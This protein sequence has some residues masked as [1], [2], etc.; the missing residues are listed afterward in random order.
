MESTFLL[1]K[2][3]DK[4]YPY[5]KN[6]RNRCEANGIEVDEFLMRY[7]GIECNIIDAHGKVEKVEETFIFFDQTKGEKIIIAT[8]T[9]KPE[10][11]LTLIGFEVGYFHGKENIFSSIWHELVAGEIEDLVDYVPKLNLFYLFDDYEIAKNYLE[12]HH[13]LQKNGMDVENG[14][15]FEV[16]AVYEW[17]KYHRQRKI[18]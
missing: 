6:L 12:Q 10:S 16:I 2:K 4:T 3:F 11:F 5:L 13:Q 15:Y 7:S 17:K 9:E 8:G 14:E 18:S 1:R